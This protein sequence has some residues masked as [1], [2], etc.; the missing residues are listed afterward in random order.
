MPPPSAVLS[1][2]RAKRAVVAAGQPVHAEHQVDLLER[3]RGV[4]RAGGAPGGPGRLTAARRR[5]VGAG[6]E[7]VAAERACAPGVRRRRGRR[8]RP[9]R[10][11]CSRAGSGCGR[12]G[13]SGRGSA[14]R[15][16][17]RCRRSGGPA[18]RRPR[19][20]SANRLCTTSSGSSSCIAISSRI[21]SRSASTS[22][23][24]DQRG[25]DHVA[26]HVDRQ[27]QVV[28][29][30]PR[31][32]AGVLLGGEGVELAADRVERDRDVHARTARGC[33]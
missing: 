13:R 5:R 28:V 10:P 26:E 18:A 23:V 21:T 27:R 6:E 32:E 2:P 1:T 11:P 16:T 20:G 31:V 24:A 14:R 29:E 25:G 33:P 8:C 3:A 19:P 22:S 4:R 7:A 15:S 17:R 9:P 30:H 12:T